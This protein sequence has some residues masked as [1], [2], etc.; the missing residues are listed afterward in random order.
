MR[1]FLRVL[2]SLLVAGILLAFLAFFGEVR[3]DDVARAW[4][5]LSLRTYCTALAFHV[6]LYLLRALR[7]Y[8]LIPPEQRPPLGRLTVV[9]SAHTMAATILPAKI[10]EA[11]FIVYLRDVC[12]V[13]AVVGTASLVVSRLLD[14]ATLTLGMSIACLALGAAGTY[15]QVGW[16]SSAGWLLGACSLGLF[17]VSARG[18]WLALTASAF[19]HRVGLDRLE[20]GRRI[21]ART[22]QVADALRRAGGERRLYAAALVSLPIWLCVF[23]FCAV[24]ARG[25]GLPESVT[26]AEATFASSLA[27][28]TSLIPISA[29]ASFGTLEAGWVLGFGVLG[30][31]PTLAAATALGMHLVQLINVIGLGLLGHLGMGLATRTHRRG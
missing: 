9:S 6:L 25:L 28:V 8:I 12:G 2:V 30:I 26:L 13:S 19:L 22:E 5:T 17:A 1:P 3:G 24:L 27:I 21:L 29:F 4:R 16:F 7:F 11:T 18:D 23:L 31:D 10:G 15:P 14:M 20:R